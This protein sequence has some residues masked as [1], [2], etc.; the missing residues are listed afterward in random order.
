MKT[1]FIILARNAKYVAEKINELER[2][3]VPY[4]VI[5]GE[6]VN[7][8]NVVYRE[9]KGKYDALNLSKYLIP[10]NAEIVAF[11]DVDTRFGD[12]YPMLQYFKDSRVGI[13]FAPELVTAGPQTRF[14]TLFNPIRR[15]LPLAASGELMLIRQEILR[16]LLPMRACKAED[17]YLMFKALELGYKV[18]FSEECPTWTE[19]TKTGTEEEA[20][21]RR[22]VVGIYQALS[23]TKPPAI[24]R[25]IYALLPFAGFLLVILGSNGYHWYRGIL[26]GFLD[27]KRGDRS[28]MWK[29]AYQA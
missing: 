20:Y 4:L 10:R 7:H 15:V 28:G 29:T 1:F 26:L 8:P 9:P 22:T 6:K 12:F 2:L 17:T 3:C 5:C 21:K 23:S 27:Y 16:K 19:R 25:F 24:V 14:F 18:V 11:N 13:V